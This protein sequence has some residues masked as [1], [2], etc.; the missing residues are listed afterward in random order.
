M[1]TKHLIINHL[2][3]GT[4]NCS[5]LLPHL[6]YWCRAKANSSSCLSSY[7][8]LFAFA[9][10]YSGPPVH[11]PFSGWRGIWIAIVHFTFFRECCHVEKNIWVEISI[12]LS[13][14]MGSQ[15]CGEYLSSSKLYKRT[16]T[17][18]PPGPVF[19]YRLRY[20]AGFGLVEMAIST[21]PKPAIY[22]N[23]NENT[24]PGVSSASRVM[25]SSQLHTLWGPLICLCFIRRNS[26]Q[27]RVP[28]VGVIFCSRARHSHF[29]REG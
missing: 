2:G 10:H 27:M 19:S 14:K 23:L 4:N 12:R 26:W 6:I 29:P 28:D 1:F 21:N 16:G 11:L 15:V 20:I 25:P 24:G 13:Y 18:G 22:R 3:N 17:Q 5:P 9:G 8:R 7:S